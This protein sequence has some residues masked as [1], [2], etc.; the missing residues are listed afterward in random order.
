MMKKNSNFNQRSKKKRKLNRL[1]M[2]ELEKSYS[3]LLK[4]GQKKQSRNLLKLKKMK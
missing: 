3:E 1:K 2:K 4:D